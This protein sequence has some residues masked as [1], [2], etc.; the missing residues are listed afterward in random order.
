M[1]PFIFMVLARAFNNPKGGSK[2]RKGFTMVLA[3][4]FCLTITMSAFAGDAEYVGSKA[5]KKCHIKVFKSWEKTKHANTLD[6]LKAGEAA[7]AKTKHGL[8]PAKDYT[9]DESCLA[10][11]SVGFGKPGG[12]AVPAD[13]DAAKKVKDLVGVGCESC[14]GAGGGY[15]ELH[16]AIQKEK[17]EYT[18]DEMKAAGLVVP[19]E[20][21]CKSCHNDKSPTHEG[22]DFAAAKDKGVHEHAPL[23]YRK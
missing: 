13:E 9:T 7:E 20:A 8:D 18:L 22:F 15:I 19:D 16:T 4:A 11:H 12:Y 17:R 1:L 5:C 3:V 21:A 23:K 2:M 10:C 6:V 14:H